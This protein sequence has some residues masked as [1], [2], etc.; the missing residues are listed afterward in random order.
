[1]RRDRRVIAMINTPY[2]C[3]TQRWRDAS[4]GCLGRCMLLGLEPRLSDLHPLNPM[5]VVR[6]IPVNRVL[7][8]C[9][10]PS[11][12]ASI[13]RAWYCISFAHTEREDRSFLAED[14]S[15]RCGSD[16]H[17]N[18]V[19]VA[20]ESDPGSNPRP[21]GSIPCCVIPAEHL[22]SIPNGRSLWSSGQLASSFYMR[23]SCFRVAS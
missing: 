19:A 10:T 21:H 5:T 4:I 3:A 13:F 12:T 9:F 17:N 7:A 16:E 6:T 15:V 8:Y 18:V 2:H 1:M 22:G 14:L 23:R 11:V 20:W